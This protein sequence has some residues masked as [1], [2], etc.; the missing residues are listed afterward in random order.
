[1]S[2]GWRVDPRLRR[3]IAAA[4]DDGLV[5][6]VLIVTGDR[7]PFT[8]SD[9]DGV[10]ECVI[11]ETFARLGEQPGFVRIIPRAN[12][13][14]IMARPAFFHA[15]LDDPRVLFASATTIDLFPWA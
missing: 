6:A 12:A 13:A 4:G 2:G 14:I 9:D 11:A 15:V 10:A 3:Q 7:A 8:A 5:H 1:M